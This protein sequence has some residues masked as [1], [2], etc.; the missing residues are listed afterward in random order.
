M[1][2][3]TS[4]RRGRA[5]ISIVTL[6]V[7]LSCAPA[8]LAPA[9]AGAAPLTPGP[10]PNHWAA[11]PAPTLARASAITRP[12]WL[13]GVQITEYWPVPERWFVGRRVRPAGLN[14]E[15]RL[16]WLYSARGVTMQ[17]TGIGLD[18]RYYH[19]NALGRGGWVD[20][21]G[22]LAP[23]GGVR[24]V[25]WRAGAFWRNPLGALTFP[26]ESG[27]WHN[28]R[29]VRFLPLPG[30]TFEPGHGRPGLRS[31]RSLAVDPALIPM[32]SRVF[33]PAYKGKGGGWFTAQDTGGAIRGRHV[34]VYRNPPA[35]EGEAAQSLAAQRILV[36]PPGQRVPA[37]PPPAPGPGSGSGPATG[38]SPPGD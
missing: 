24:E 8:L 4:A 13:S 36:I 35:R 12:T 38:G 9:G 11:L 18:G 34:D 21:L 17:G 14:T 7:A 32:G 5:R 19:V 31:Y 23:I 10:V 6:A 22:R 33:I 2:C 30:V 16:D 1:H 26:L 3:P 28:G 37:T 27:G 25:F 29:G 20:R 15:H